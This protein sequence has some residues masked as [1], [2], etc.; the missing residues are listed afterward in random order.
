[1]GSAPET[2][3]AIVEFAE[4]MDPYLAV[5]GMVSG[6]WNLFFGDDE[7]AEILDMLNQIQN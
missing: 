6:L 7:Y 5:L 4:F 2:S 3:N 1:M